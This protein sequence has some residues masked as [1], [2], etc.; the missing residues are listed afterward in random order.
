M[1]AYGEVKVEHHMEVN[2]Q[3][4]APAASSPRETPWYPNRRR[5]VGP[6]TG[7]DIV[8]KKKQ[9]GFYRDW[10]PGRSA[11]SIVT[12]MSEQPVPSISPTLPFQL[13]LTN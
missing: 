10:N 11:R 8:E 5:L 2:A 13:L 3:L 7:V 1:K 6:Q 4:H 9:T 12:I